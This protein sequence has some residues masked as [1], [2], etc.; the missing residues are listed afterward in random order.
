MKKVFAALAA[1]AVAVSMLAFAGCGDKGGNKLPD[2]AIPGDYQDASQEQL[3]DVLDDILGGILGGGES[4]SGDSSSTPVVN[5]Y[6]YGLSIDLAES[7]SIAGVQNISSSVKADLK[8]KSTNDGYIGKGTASVSLDS[9]SSGGNY[10][11]NKVNFN[12]TAY[13]Q[14][15]VIY[16][17]GEGS[18]YSKEV[19]GDEVDENTTDL[20]KKAKIN[21]ATLIANVGGSDDNSVSAARDEVADSSDG[22]GFLGAIQSYLT[23]E[24]LYTLAETYSVS[25]G[26]DTKDGIKIKLSASEDTVWAVVASTVGEDLTEAELNEYKSGVKFNKFLFDVYFSL[27]KDGLLNGASVVCDIDVKIDSSLLGGSSE[28]GY[29]EDNYKE[30]TSAAPDDSVPATTFS[31][32]GSVKIY[33]HDDNVT[34]PGG[35][36]DDEEYYD[37]TDFILGM[38]NDDDDDNYGDSSYVL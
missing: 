32:K 9:N 27:D 37:A 11:E 3:G 12:G 16:A 26:L 2:G 14:D 29:G 25:I 35:L 20:N 10:E 5:N 34:V 4:G 24:N 13:L 8:L 23:A 33:T 22:L 36:A 21:L 19:D 6:N 17:I 18:A 7:A 30:A 31:L 15:M 28:G 1:S 38:I